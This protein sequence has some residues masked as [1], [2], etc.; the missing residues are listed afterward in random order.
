MKHNVGKMNILKIL[1]TIFDLM[2]NDLCESLGIPKHIYHG[3]ERGWVDITK[4][5]WDLIKNYYDSQKCSKIYK[6]IVGLIIKEHEK[7]G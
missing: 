3:Y 6:K 5:D 7:T 4:T 2:P 1:R